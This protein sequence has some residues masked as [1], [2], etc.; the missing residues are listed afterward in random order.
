MNVQS[1][2]ANG[3][4]IK[5]GYA[6]YLLI[7]ELIVYFTIALRRL[8]TLY[9]EAS[10]SET[11]KQQI[12][13]IFIG[14]VLTAIPAIITSIVLPLLNN[15]AST[16]AAYYGPNSAVIL[17]VFTSIAIIRHGLLDIRLVVAR[18]VGYVLTLAAITVIFIFPAILFTTKILHG[19]IPTSTAIFLGIVTCIVAII[20]QFLKATFDKV[21]R[22]IFFRDYYNFQDVLDELGDLL[23]RSI[24]LS[25]IKSGSSKILGKP[26]KSSF[27]KYAL[28]TDKDQEQAGLTEKLLQ[29]KANVISTDDLD[30]SKHQDVYTGLNDASV[31]LAIRLRT[32]KEDLG[33]MMVGYKK[34]GSL[35]TQTDSRLLTI[36]ADEVAV[37]L[38]NALR[39][40][41]IQQFNITLQDRV[42]EATIKLRRANEKLRALDETKDDFIS[43]ASHQLRT[44]LT[45]IKGYLSMV[46]EGDVGKI[47]KPQ[48]DMLG[49]AFFSSQRM[50]YLIADLLNV[51]RLK[52][53]KFIIE[54]NPVNLSELVQQELSQLDETTNQRT[55]PLLT[56]S[57]RPFLP[58]CLMKL[59]HVR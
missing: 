10:T 15:G 13:Y 21:T 2:G 50:V 58:L 59:R 54:S 36:A 26:L 45:S 16:L 1:I 56:I 29:F 47:T 14:I 3:L 49:Q 44:P 31:S 37:G 18:S 4:N 32:T 51:S 11:Q 19:T 30:I 40:E 57:Q 25:E 24:D 39:F 46:L 20:F 8:Y 43:M 53:G 55:L 33:F 5:P 41:E 7:V 38:Q 27:I 17:A 34:S 22:R 52:T 9:K 48:K 23:V 35:Y 28:L 42:D 12:K 6:Y